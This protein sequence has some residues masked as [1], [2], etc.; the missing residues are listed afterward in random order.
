MT[1][2]PQERRPGPQ[3]D[4]NLEP[5]DSFFDSHYLLAYIPLLP[6]DRSRTEALDAVRLARVAPGSAVLGCPGV[7]GAT[8]WPWPAR[9]IASSASIGPSRRLARRDAVEVRHAGQPC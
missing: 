3:P 7:S 6:D 1:N 4:V 9:G 5:W 8:R 2:V